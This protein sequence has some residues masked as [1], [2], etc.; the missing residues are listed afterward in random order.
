MR[1][2]RGEPMDISRHIWETKYRTLE[3]GV[4]VEPIDPLGWEER[5]Y[6]LLQ[7][8]RFLPG[9][10]IQAGAGTAHDVTLF[11]RFVM[12]PVDDSIPRIFRALQEAAIAMQKGGGIGVDFSTVRPRGTTA[13]ETGSIASGPFSFMRGFDVRHDPVDGISPRRDD[14]GDELRPSGY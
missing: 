4:T 2:M 3:A 8:Y 1:A 14:G 10:R 13:R 7:D 6:R 9:G 5:F 12:G 11:D